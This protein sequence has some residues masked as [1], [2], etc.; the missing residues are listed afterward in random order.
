MTNFDFLQADSTFECFAQ[1]AICAEKVIT[2]DSNACAINCRIA[3]ERAI[4]WLYSVE[5]SLN[6]PYQDDLYSLLSSE[7]FRKII[8]PELYKR[9]DYIRRLGNIAAHDNRRRVSREEALL[10]L[11]NL[12]IFVDFIAYCYSSSDYTE[13][14]FDPSLISK[15]EATLALASQLPNV[16][17]EAL[18]K[19]NEQL[20]QKLSERSQKQRPN[21]QDV[22]LEKSEYETRKLYIDVMLTEAGWIEDRNWL[23]EVPIDNMPT[24]SGQGRA[25][26]VLYGKDGKPLAIIEAKKSCADPTQGRQQAKLY[27]DSLEKRYG[28]RPIIFLTNGFDTKI[29][30]GQY[31]ERKVATFYSQSDLEKLFNLRSN[32]QSLLKAK[33]DPKIADRY[34]Q[35]AA[36]QAICSAFEKK[37]R[38]K[39]LLV[40]ATG[41]GKTRTIIAL[42]DILTKYSWAKNILFLADRNALVTQAK[43]SFVNLLPNLTTVNLCDEKD[44]SARC[45]CSTYQTINKLIDKAESQEGQKVFTCGHFDLIICDEAHRSI[46]NKYKD[47]IEYFDAPIVGL[48]ATP[49]QDIDRNTYEIF[50]LEDGVPT[51]AYELEQAVKDSFLVTYKSIETK[52]KFMNGG[53][54]YDELSERDQEEYEE[55]F[56]DE[57]DDIPSSIASSALNKTVFNKDTIVKVLDKLM[58]DGLKVDYNNRIGKTIIFAVNHHH[59]EAIS[60]IFAEQYPQF[61]NFAQ[62]IDNQTKFSQTLIDDFSDPKKLPQIAISVDM[63]DTGIDIPE[64]LNLVFFKKVLSPCKFWQMIGR[65]TRLCPKLIDGQ[66]KTHFCIFDWYNN[67]EY[68]RANPH[69]QTVTATPSLSAALFSLQFEIA[70]S[71]QDLKYQT[72]SLISWRKKLV[73]EMVAKVLQLNKDNFAVRQHL[74]VVERYSQEEN[75]QT[76]E[77]K[78]IKLVKEELAPLISGDGTEDIKALRFDA[79]LYGLELQALE[80]KPSRKRKKDLQDKAESLAG[81]GNIPDIIKHAEMINKITQTDFLNQA[82]AADFEQV[83]VELRDLLKFLPNQEVEIYETNFTDDVLSVEENEADLASDILKNYKAKVEF[84]IQQHQNSGAIAKLKN[85]IPLNQSDW[86][87]LEHTLW[88]ELGSRDDYQ[89]EYGD[90][91]LGK[92]IRSIVGLDMQAAKAAFSQY[93]DETN[94]SSEQ[95]Y[96]VNQIVEYIVQNGLLEDMTILQDTPFTD[97]GNIYELFGDNKSAWKN[98]RSIIEQITANAIAA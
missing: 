97:R 29:I 92:F 46:Y 88:N 31:P 51:Y 80:G 6:Q 65:G 30:D 53:I 64:V 7:E 86:Q 66:D 18:L 93:L 94:F 89:A 34:Y 14:K 87:E 57:N 70:R 33:V 37:N 77:F 15:S 58:H 82:E 75:Y 47:I 10:C 38:R 40:M 11:E 13:R 27:A 79:L 52:L 28:R 42:S 71:L 62:V 24:K 90:K 25:D 59:A 68:F 41:S 50:E 60:K 63:L 22:P 74:R 95:I 3:M 20:R 73:K 4:K 2:A 32:R 19:E 17:L 67:F 48:T 55:K 16:D 8:S 21:Y 81:F 43:R 91:P 69:G 98:I 12:F 56:K 96:F 84:Y 49:K 35:K 39:A 45:V 23:N 5:N 54:H 1:A 44:Y 26:Y 85:N 9:L 76:I 83:R 61:K 78:D 36:I 72:E